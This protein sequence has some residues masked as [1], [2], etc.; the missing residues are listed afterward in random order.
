MVKALIV[1]ATRSGA[2]KKIAELIAEGFRSEGGDVKVVNVNGIK[3]EADLEGFNAYTF[4]SGTYHGDM[5]QSLKTMLFLAEKVN[6]EGTAGGS[7][8][9]FGWSGE[10]SGRIYDTMKNIFKM[11]VVSGP[12]RL[13]SASLGGGAQKAQDYGREVGVKASVS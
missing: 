3:K 9:A 12:L 11:D 5:M 6:F 13:N 4:G 1:Y 2:T 10:A 7:F 8:G